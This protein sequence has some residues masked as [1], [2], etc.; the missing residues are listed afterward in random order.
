[1]HLLRIFVAKFVAAE[2]IDEKYAEEFLETTS[3][4]RNMCF[5]I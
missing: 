4:V 1:M 5:K 3:Q 2:K